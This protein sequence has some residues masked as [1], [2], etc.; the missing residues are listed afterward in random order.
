MRR[1]DWAEEDAVDPRRRRCGPR[2]LADEVR[3][4]PVRFDIMRAGGGRRWKAFQLFRW[5]Y[6][7]VC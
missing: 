3:S 7:G 1:R 5:A 2:D 4:G 6:D